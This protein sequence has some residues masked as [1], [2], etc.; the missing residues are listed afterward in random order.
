MAG[1]KRVRCIDSRTYIQERGGQLREEFGSDDSIS[2]TRGKVY[3]VL[4]EEDDDYRIID[5]TG[6]DYLYPKCMFEPIAD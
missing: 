2:L 3:S 5:D 4:A 6:E 1:L